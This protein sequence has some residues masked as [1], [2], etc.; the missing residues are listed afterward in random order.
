M[1]AEITWPQ[2]RRVGTIRFGADFHQSETR[3]PYSGCAILEDHGDHCVI[4]PLAGALTEADHNAIL[5]RCHEQ[6][7]TR[8]RVERRGKHYEY[9]LAVRPFQRRRIAAEVSQDRAPTRQTLHYFDVIAA[10]EISHFPAERRAPA[11]PAPSRPMVHPGRE[12][13][14]RLV[15]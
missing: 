2:A 11:R 6:G 9:D 10:P 3:D 12:E 13:K 5:E 14:V 4:G 7:F 1:G 8:V 15:G